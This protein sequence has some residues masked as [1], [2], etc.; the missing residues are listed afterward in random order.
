M[1]EKIMARQDADREDL[2]GEA[3]ALVERA[4]L[5]LPEMVEPLTAGRRR[6]GGWSTY[7][8]GDPCYH[9][10]EQG[11]L[12]RAFAEGRLYRTQGATLAELERV[13]TADQTE[14]RRR[15][16]TPAELARFLETARHR[17]AELGAAIGQGTIQVE[18]V[19]PEGAIVTEKLEQALSHILD[20]GLRLA[21]SIKGRL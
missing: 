1:P 9:F 15:D 13:R 16:L 5:S 10:D 8:G 6:T 4:E 18:R 2:F 11:R 12:R 17:L 14:L 19:F 7:F 21:P 20:R 3:A